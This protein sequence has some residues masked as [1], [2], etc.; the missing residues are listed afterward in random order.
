MRVNVVASTGKSSM[1]TQHVRFSTY[2]L[3]GDGEDVVVDAVADSLPS[4]S[5]SSSGGGG[6]G[7]GDG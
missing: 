2:V 1:H 7:G 6:G 5:A 3:G 4:S